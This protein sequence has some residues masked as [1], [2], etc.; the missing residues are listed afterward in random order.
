MALERRHLD[1]GLRQELGH[2]PLDEL[3]VA[4]VLDDA[5]HAHHRIR[6]D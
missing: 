2:E 5:H 6:H 4:V 3:V 1:Q